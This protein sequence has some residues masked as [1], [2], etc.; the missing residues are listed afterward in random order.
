MS[1]ARRIMR[2]ASFPLIK[3][4]WK[5]KNRHNNTSM[6]SR[7][8]VEKVEV[9]RYTYGKLDV[10]FFG[11][12]DEKLVIG[13]LCSIASGVRFICGGGHRMDAFSTFPFER[14]FFGV[15]EAV[16]KGPIVVEDDVWIGTNA[17]ILSGVKICRGAVVAAG[18]V[19]VR[20]VPPY[21]IVGGVPARPISY[22]FDDETI[23]QL[24][25]IDYSAIDADFIRRNR[26]LLNAA[27][28]DDV[29]AALPKKGLS[30]L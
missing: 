30:E 24:M 18:A 14:K 11:E 1:L 3:L 7:F 28:N 17:L 27:L 10:S 6:A 21:A 20:D 29:L 23:S 2:R 25:R 26:E 8:D 5:I 22:R 15:V 13:D 9:G 16:N 4:K 19:V 12:K